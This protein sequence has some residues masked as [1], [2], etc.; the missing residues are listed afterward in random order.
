[1]MA[2][3][4]A[5]LRCCCPV[6]S[7]CRCASSSTSSSS[8]PR[9]RAGVGR[10]GCEGG[11]ACGV[12]AGDLDDA[13]A[14]LGG[15]GDVGL[16]YALDSLVLVALGGGAEKEAEAVEVVLGRRGGVPAGHQAEADPVHVVL[17]GEHGEVLQGVELV[18]ALACGV[19]ETCGDLVLPRL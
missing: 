4:I 3:L 14:E 7:G 12:D 5:S 18:A 11:A 2:S 9:I 8:G 15:G 19:G 10:S 13:L 16:V 1:M 6:R 17:R